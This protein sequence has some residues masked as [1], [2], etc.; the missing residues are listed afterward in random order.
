MDMLAATFYALICGGLAAAA[1]SLPSFVGR[2]VVGALTGVVA[3]VVLPFL[4][5]LVAG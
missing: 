2:I 3:S 5:T 1:P 4:R